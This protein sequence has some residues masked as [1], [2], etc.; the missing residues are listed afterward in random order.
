[1]NKKKQIGCPC[2]TPKLKEIKKKKVGCQSK[3]QK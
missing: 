2:D 3:T 1:M